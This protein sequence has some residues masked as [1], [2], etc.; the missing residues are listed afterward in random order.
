MTTIKTRT[1]EALFP[2]LSAFHEMN[3]LRLRAVR[4]GLVEGLLVSII[5]DF[6]SR[7][8]IVGADGDD[9]TVEFSIID[10]SDTERSRGDDVSQAAPWKFFI[11]REFTWGWVMVNQRGYLD[12]LALSFGEAVPQLIVTVVASS[13][14]A[15][16]VR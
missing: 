2:L 6:E 16:S 4:Q 3:G 10:S 9:D 14:K 13:L 15:A 1:A 11:E 12:G 8:L 5:L 7:A